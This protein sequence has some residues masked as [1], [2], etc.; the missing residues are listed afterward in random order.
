MAFHSPCPESVEKVGKSKYFLCKYRRT[1]LL[2][3]KDLENKG[4]TGA[5]G[6]QG[7]AG[8]WGLTPWGT[9]WITLG[10]GKGCPW[11]MRWQCEH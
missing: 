11:V 4:G 9:H 3:L 8:V 6:L 10:K 7:V 5:L 1:G 2:I